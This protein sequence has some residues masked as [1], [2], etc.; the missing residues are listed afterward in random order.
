MCQLL[1]TLNFRQRVVL[2]IPMDRAKS[3]S[4]RPDSTYLLYS[5]SDVRGVFFSSLA[6]FSPTLTSISFK[7]SLVM[8]LEELKITALSATF[9]SSLMLPWPGVSLQALQGILLHHRRHNIQRLALSF[10]ESL[11]DGRNVIQP[12][13]ER[14]NVKG[15]KIDPIVQV[16]SE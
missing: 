9:L 5:S 14:R 4:V 10:H 3:F 1:R 6:F 12:F 11:E 13:P 2:L 7:V 15:K 8:Q 16:P